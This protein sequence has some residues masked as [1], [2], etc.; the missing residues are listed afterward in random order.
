[1]NESQ[2]N[3][4]RKAKEL[5]DL[6]LQ[7]S[8]ERTL[9]EGE[10]NESIVKFQKPL[11]DSFEQQIPI[12]N[13]LRDDQKILNKVYVE[14][15]KYINE[16]LEKGNQ[17][18]KAIKDINEE[19]KDNISHLSDPK[20]FTVH[21]DK[22][23]D[24]EYLQSKGFPLPSTLINDPEDLVIQIQNIGQLNK[25]LGGKIGGK[26]KSKDKLDEIAMYKE[27]IKNNK[28]YLERLKTIQ[29]SQKVFKIQQKGKG[30]DID[31]I[32]NELEITISKYEKNPSK[33][34]KRLIVFILNILLD[35]KII[36][37]CDYS[38]YI[39]QIF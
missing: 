22:D 28:L 4:I 24:E 7:E 15:A 23:L 36:T 29:I 6:W 20:F 5:K 26:G 10:I 38:S 1:M 8:K 31:K 21:L 3:K 9:T 32:V 34:L 18:I 30:L 13:K 16:I 25:V 17:E 11:V 19:T 33:K 27:R 14:E 39:N 12:L 37:I 35:L 2:R